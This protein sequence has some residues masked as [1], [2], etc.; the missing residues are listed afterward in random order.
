MKEGSVQH[1]DFLTE[2]DKDI[3]KT[4]FEIDQQWVIEH[5]ADR[6]PYICQGQSVNLFFPA[7]SDKSYINSVHLRAWKKELKGLYYL[8]TSSGNDA[9]K[10]GMKIERNAL[11]DAEECISCHG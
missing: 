1:L 2:Q 6:Q 9:D 4:A 11:K 8:R 10:V 3:F 7:G 5:A